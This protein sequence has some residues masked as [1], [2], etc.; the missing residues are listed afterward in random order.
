MEIESFGY[1]GVRSQALDDWRSYGPNFLGL[2]PV[3]KSRGLLAFRMDDRKQRLIVREDNSNGA[4]FF[5]WEVK[6]SDALNRLANRLD[7]AGIRVERLPAAIANERHVKDLI[8]FHDP[9]CNRLEVFHGAA[10]ASSPFRPGRAISG[11]RTGP[12]GMGHIVLTVERIDQVM[13]FYV[14]VLGF[15]LS[16]FALRPFKA[17]FF[18]VNARHHSL[19]L[20]E[21]GTN[22]IHHLMMELFSLDDVGQAYDLAQG[23]EGRIGAT[24]GRHT[25]DFMTSF[26]AY[27]PSCFMVEYGWGGRNIRPETWTSMELEHGPSL[28]GHDRTWLPPEQRAEAREMRLKAAEL[29]VRQ[30]VQVIKGNHELMAGT[31]PWWDMTVRAAE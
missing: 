5:G 2:E 8:M 10:V 30:P 28:W 27:T 1:I 13:P 7:N 6:D 18:H 24:L 12:V 14:D 20:I 19:A 3:E 22:G 17:Y 4:D 29:G 15:K 16:D 26:Y 31:C 21:T 9:A 23:E 11:F 25:N